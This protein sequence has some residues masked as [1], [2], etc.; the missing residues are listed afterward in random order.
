MVLEVRPGHHSHRVR[1]ADGA[2][3]LGIVRGLGELN[4]PEPLPDALLESGPP[5]IE[6]QVVNGGRLVPAFVL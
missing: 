4:L 2:C 1:R 3:N 5:D 6:R